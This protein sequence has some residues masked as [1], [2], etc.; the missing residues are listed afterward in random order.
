MSSLSAGRRF[1]VGVLG[2]A[3]VGCAQTPPGPT[4]P[5]TPQR[6][7]EPAG[8]AEPTA[9]GVEGTCDALVAG[10]DLKAAAGQLVMVGVT[11]ALDDAATKA[12]KAAKIGSA[13]LMGASGDGVSGT[14][15][16][17]D[18]I[19]NAGDS[20]GVLIGVAQ[21]GGTATPL[22]GSGFTQ[23][24]SAAQ[25]AKLS[26]EELM[27]KAAVLGR[28]LKAAGVNLNLAPVADVV[29]ESKLTSQPVGQ[30]E[31]GYGTDPQQV[32]AKVS[33]VVDGL[34]SSGIGATV[35]HFPNLGQVSGGVDGTA[36]VVDDVTTV[37]D[38][39]LAPYRQTIDEGV[40]SV[41]I[42]TIYYS[43]IDGSEPAVFSQKV[44]GMVRELGFEGV[45]TSD[46]LGAATTV[47]DVPAKLRA[48][49]FLQAGGDLAISVD[50]AVATEMVAGL[51][52][53]GEADPK[54]AAKIKAAAVRVM[55]LKGRLGVTSCQPAVG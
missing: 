47:A 33:V 41:M 25:Q 37:D 43:K 13:V 20:H 18:A 15:A 5:S 29:P 35:K 52:A 50:P 32:A 12:I 38:P 7:P 3:L 34:Q 16:R 19:R 54:F 55:T 31:R 4:P 17:T 26:Q 10:M 30:L 44:V 42:S 39:A 1:L 48:V 36:K 14:K 6:A 11:G 45:I 40:A 21:E 28:E 9:S 2:F 27:S 51:V 8:S 22:T 53:A 46:D 49:K 23:M 24:P